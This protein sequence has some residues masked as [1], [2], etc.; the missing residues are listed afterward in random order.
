MV[1]F[2]LRR[3]MSLSRVSPVLAGAVPRPPADVL[4]R[5]R[6]PVRSC[7]G[8]GE[9]APSPSVPGP[10]HARRQRLGPF[11]PKPRAP[12]SPLGWPASSPAGGP[13][14]ALRSER[15]AQAAVAALAPCRN[16]GHSPVSGGC[17]GLGSTEEAGERLQTDGERWRKLFILKKKKKK[18]VTKIL[19]RSKA[20][21][22]TFG[23]DDLRG[24]FQP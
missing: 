1:L 8:P 12:P 3:K 7:P 14:G 23:P 16:R 24:L 10:P 11:L 20:A 17:S 15:A 9:P 4:A 2:F 13:A 6:T 21:D 5:H 18:M 22:L 19:Y